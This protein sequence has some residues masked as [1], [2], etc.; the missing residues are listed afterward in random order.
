[1]FSTRLTVLVG[2]ALCAAVVSLPAAAAQSSPAPATGAS[3]TASPVAPGQGSVESID[4]VGDPLPN[5]E[6]TVSLFN[7]LGGSFALLFFGSGQG[8]NALPNGCVLWV[9]PVLPLLLT[10]PLSG[11]NPGEGA[12]T[13]VGRLPPATP[14]GMVI[15]MQALVADEGADGGISSTNAIQLTVL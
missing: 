15:T 10:V 14:P 4:L 1:M 12:A 6:L 3:T 2:A 11:K 5:G 8:K 7:A 13:L 9:Q